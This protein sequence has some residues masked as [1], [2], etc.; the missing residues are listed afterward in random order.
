MEHQLQNLNLNLNLNLKI[1]YKYNNF[2]AVITN[3]TEIM[4]DMKNS[5]KWFVLLFCPVWWLN[6]RIFR[7]NM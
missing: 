1:Y 4:R 3:N 2:T 6:L 5:R 7:R